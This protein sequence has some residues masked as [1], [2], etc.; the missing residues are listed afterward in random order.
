MD[1]DALPTILEI[2]RTLGGQCKEFRCR[3][4]SRDP[5]RAIVLFVSSVPYQVGDLPLPS[6]TVTLGHFWPGRDYNVYHWL[7]PDGETLGHYFNLAAD[8]VIGASSISWCD[9]V[10]DL[11]VRP[12]APPL[13]LD[14]ADIPPNLPAATHARLE[15]ARRS[16][17]EE[18]VALIPMLEREAGEIWPR[19]FG[20]A[21]P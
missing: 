16:V 15:A 2:K 9:L 11:L 14:E 18:H 21:R 20:R 13:L 12:G 19:L 1:P 17:L 7:T 3:L 8:T 10:L 5:V 6:G 4:V